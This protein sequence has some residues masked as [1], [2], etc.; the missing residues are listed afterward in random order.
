MRPNPN[1]TPREQLI[2]I[3]NY[4]IINGLYPLNQCFDALKKA[5]HCSNEEVQKAFTSINN[6]N[7]KAFGPNW[8]DIMY[9]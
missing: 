7:T 5:K 6:N 1:Q 3:V 4:N 9:P 2:N 8:Y